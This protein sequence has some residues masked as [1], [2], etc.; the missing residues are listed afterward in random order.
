[1]STILPLN[2]VRNIGI[3]AHIDAGKTTATERVLYYSGKIHKVGEVHDGQSV[4]DWMDQEKERGITIT[5]AAT[6]TSWRGHEINIIDTPGH[7]DFTAEVERSLRVLDGAIALFCAVGGV[8]PQSETVWRQSE[9]YNIP[10]I[11]FV[12]KMDRIGADY[13]AVLKEIED[14]L[15][16]NV[17]PI[18]IPIGAEDNFRGI[19]DLVEM[20]AVYYDDPLLNLK[21]EETEIPEDM[22][23]LAEEYRKLLIEKVSE[24]DEELFEMYIQGKQP[25]QQKIRLAIRDATVK[26]EVVPVMAGAAYKNKGIRRLL[27]AIVDYLP[28]PQDRPPII[29]ITRKEDEKA[30]ARQQSDDEPF[31]AL[32]FKVVTDKHRGK[33]SFIRVYSG[34]A[35]AGSF[36]Y[37]ST[38]GKKQRIGR[39]FQIHANKIESKESIYAGEIGAIV[40]INESS[41]GDTICQENHPILLEAIEFP[42]PVVFV[43]V[44]PASRSDRDRLGISLAKLAQE[45]PTFMVRTNEETGETVISGMGELHLEILLDRLKREFKVVTEVG[46]PQVSYRETIYNRTVETTKYIKQ[47]GGHGQYAHVVI[48]L[49]PLPEG[50]GFEFNNKIIGGVIPKEFIPAVQKG[51]IDAME[52][53]P[54]AGYPVVNVRVSLIDG[55]FH[56]VDSSD[57]AFRTAGAMCFRSAFIKAG[58]KLL[59][60]IMNVDVTT[61]EDYLGA[62]TGSIVSKRGKI[63]NMDIKNG[64][65][66]VKAQAPLA[67]MFGYTNELRNVT[68]G[69]ASA[70]MTFNHYEVVPY[71]IAEE[72]VE[73]KR[74]A[75]EKR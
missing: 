66:V 2:K 62:V 64:T 45:D 71:S 44:K 23:A 54:Y 60:P 46:V 27:D 13:F 32:I 1:M 5:S 12:N 20:K 7:V 3:M 52:E 74:K 59:E 34:S 61:P 49:E 10:K 63:L 8:Q 41:T 22:K 36:V 72:I 55:S 4:M 6:T 33:L 69:R 30:P 28:S 68:S 40:G 16:A 51:V 14:I 37:N 9:K 21:Y 48:D 53:G 56:P 65:R 42:Q 70:S 25:S 67:E 31:A 19:I 58:P 57:M 17:L 18:T 26:M 75:R 15:G 38:I 73:K 11:A 39:I 29:G 47:T 35:Q 43:S 24:Q 50:K